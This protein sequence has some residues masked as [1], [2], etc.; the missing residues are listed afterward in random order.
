MNQYNCRGLSG[1]LSGLM[2]YICVVWSNIHVILSITTGDET[3]SQRKVF[4]LLTS[5]QAES[6]NMLMLSKFTAITGD[7]CIWN[8][9]F[10][11]I[12]LEF[13]SPWKKKVWSPAFT[14]ITPVWGYFILAA[15]YLICFVHYLFV[16]SLLLTWSLC[17]NLL[18]RWLVTSC[19]WCHSACDV[20][21]VKYMV[22]LNV[23]HNQVAQTWN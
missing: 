13:I 21:H 15:L 22:T 23:A 7:L 17:L 10:D 12:V 11:Y 6:I 14:Q 18:K 1:H 4:P 8:I 3:R 2:M 19:M 16:T 5:C 20:I 9:L